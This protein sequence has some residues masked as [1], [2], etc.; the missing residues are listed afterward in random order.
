MAILLTRTPAFRAGLRVALNE[1][2]E[3]QGA[4]SFRF[5]RPGRWIEDPETL[6]FRFDSP[7]LVRANLRGP[8]IEWLRERLPPGRPSTP[9]CS[10]IC[11]WLCRPVKE[12]ALRG[13][14]D[15]LLGLGFLC[16]NNPWET[17]DLAPEDRLLEYLRGLAAGE[18]MD[19]IAATLERLLSLLASYSSSASP[20]AVVAAGKKATRDLAAQAARLA[21]V[22]PRF[23]ASPSREWFFQEDVF[24]ESDL[25]SRAVAHLDATEAHGL[26]T[27]L[28]PLVR[29]SNLYHSRHD[30]HHA[31]S[32]FASTRW[33]DQ[34]QVPFLDFFEKALPLFGAY[35]KHDIEARAGGYLQA[36]VWN[37]LALPAVESL[38]VCREDVLKSLQDCLSHDGEAMLLDRSALEDLLGQVAEPYVA[39]RD[40]AAFL[41]PV[42]GASGGWALNVLSDGMGRSSSRYSAAMDVSMRERYTSFFVA[43]SLRQDGEEPGE[44]SISSAPAATRPTPMRRRP[45]VF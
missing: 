23:T 4:E 10:P 22:D 44:A 9:I 19:E 30:F 40:F 16:W 45:G 35:V 39:R 11:G 8:L 36:S 28:A 24:V 14:L 3:K 27:D 41:Q 20:G 42:A 31:L 6:D 7:A 26:L 34:D 29:L 25:P 38:R 43:N 17:F 21:G 12:A 2:L 37:P 15:K 18:A 13:S 5:I 1:T 33:A 32:A